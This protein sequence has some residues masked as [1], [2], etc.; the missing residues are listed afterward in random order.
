MSYSRNPPPTTSNIQEPFQRPQRTIL[1]FGQED[2]RDPL[3]ESLLRESNHLTRSE[4]LLDEQFDLAIKTRESL[5]NQRWSIRSMQNQYNNITDR[6][7][8]V[9]TLVKRIR[10]RKRRDTI[11]VAIVFSICLA[12]LLYSIFF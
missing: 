9:T 1:D 11:I 12:L 3:K 7:Q 10:I 2:G 8:S 6:F 4:Q 5:V